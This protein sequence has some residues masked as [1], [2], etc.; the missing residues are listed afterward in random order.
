[1]LAV[2]VELRELQAQARSSLGTDGNVDV[3]AGSGM[4]G[5]PEALGSGGSFS[6][7]F[8]ESGRVDSAALWRALQASPNST[9][10]KIVCRALLQGGSAGQMGRTT[11]EGT[12][13]PVGTYG[14]Y[15]LGAFGADHSD[16]GRDLPLQPSGA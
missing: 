14:A 9:T 5:I 8:V 16:D 10:G 7:A 4:S 2:D 6:R 12:L 13:V 1:M 15:P 3:M 11:A